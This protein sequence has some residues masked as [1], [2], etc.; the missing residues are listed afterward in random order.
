MI[1]S[2]CIFDW[3]YVRDL[4]YEDK[5]KVLLY[6]MKLKEFVELHEVTSSILTLEF[7][8]NLRV[9]RTIHYPLGCAILINWVKMRSALTPS[10]FNQVTDSFWIDGLTILRLK[11]YGK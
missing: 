5:M 4:G 1:Y 3:D 7:L 11:M 10:L 8:S 6:K 9:K 2:T